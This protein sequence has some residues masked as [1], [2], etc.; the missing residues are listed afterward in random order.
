[1][2]ADDEERRALLRRLYGPGAEP[3]GDADAVRRLRE[4]DAGAAASIAPSPA[5]PITG[6]PAAPPAPPGPAP[7]PR[8]AWWAVLWASTLLVALV[9]ALVAMIVVPRDTA[10]PSTGGPYPGEVL[11]AT[12]QRDESFPALIP[13]MQGYDEF[14]GMR[15]FLNRSDADASCLWV[16]DPTHLEPI[17]GGWAGGGPAFSGCGAGVYAP[18]AFFAMDGDLPAPLIEQFAFGASFRMTYVTGRDVVEVFVAY[19]SDART[20]PA[21]P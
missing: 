14:Y 12:L 19:A 7:A 8:R 5:A 20:T 18:S 13:E 1:M 16:T 6:S 21:A 10:P 2:A 4:L 3:G 11:V 17:E 9:A 15:P